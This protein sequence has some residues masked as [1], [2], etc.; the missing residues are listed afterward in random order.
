MKMKS[1]ASQKVL[2]R[3]ELK[4]QNSIESLDLDTG[5]LNCLRSAGIDT[6]QEL[7]KK[8][9]KE[10]LK[11]RNLGRKRLQKIRIALNKKD[12][13]N[14]KIK[15]EEG[16][17]LVGDKID[18]EEINEIII[19]EYLVS[20]VRTAYLNDMNE[21]RLKLNELER[22]FTQL[23]PDWLLIKKTTESLTKKKE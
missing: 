13:E 17:L 3:I 16:E 23:V 6:I 14:K 11:I 20:A 8:S 15:I 10:I 22:K 1:I 18:Q 21:L 2:K 19:K 5:S 12:F 9:I 7:K 4:R